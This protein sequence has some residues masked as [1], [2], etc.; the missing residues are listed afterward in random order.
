[1][2]SPHDL[3][4]RYFDGQLS[5]DE[6]RELQN[7]LLSDVEL[8]SEFVAGAEIHGRLTNELASGNGIQLPN[9]HSRRR[10]I[11]AVFTLAASVALLLGGWWLMS[12][13][14]RDVV[15]VAET[16]N[17]EINLAIARLI[18]TDNASWGHQGESPVQL[19]EWLEPGSYQLSGGTVI[20]ALDVGGTARIE[21]PA[22]FT[23]VS[24]DRIRMNSGTLQA[25]FEEPGQGFTV[26]TPEGVIVDLG[27]EFLVDVQDRESR[28]QVV[29]GLVRA[30]VQS[31]T[32]D[33]KENEAV[34]ITAGTL[35]PLAT[36]DAEPMA[37]EFANGEPVRFYQWNFDEVQDDTFLTHGA[38]DSAQYAL[39][40]GLPGRAPE[41]IDGVVGQAIRFSGTG[42]FLESDYRGVAG[43]R[44]RTVAAWVRIPADAS[45]PESYGWAGWGR[46]AGRYSGSRKWQIS[47]NPQVRLE[48]W[49]QPLSPGS[50]VGAVRTEFGP[51]WVNG[52]RDLR[53]GQWHHVVSIF[54]GGE[55]PDVATHI[56]HYVDGRLEEASGYMRSKVE[57]RADE[58]SMMLLVG[59]HLGRAQGARRQADGK[60][61]RKPPYFTGFRG[62]VDELYIFEG[63]L[64]PVQVWRLYKDGRPPAPG[65][66]SPSIGIANH[67]AK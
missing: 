59:S 35:K 9:N 60:T 37:D 33:L 34:S 28:V 25:R 10:S 63:A 48:R 31:E 30:E 11:V 29:E 21:S 17:D 57:T 42:E 22:S 27:T 15:P 36:R 64:T 66:I 19:G 62:D 26:E 2:N 18:Y 53:D 54:I 13:R 41:R 56:R 52:T 3:M 39:R 38:N 43:S 40:P 5:D 23:I 20:M 4:I 7:A 47:W 58:E 45:P 44:P 32:R 65:M 49:K 51:G 6:T 1:M 8:R 50:T 61:P 12:D 24:G 55:D 16:N 46:Q 67:T 14:D